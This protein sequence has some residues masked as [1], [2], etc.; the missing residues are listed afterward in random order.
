MSTVFEFLKAAS[1][2]L[3]GGIKESS[4]GGTPATQHANW[5]PTLYYLVEDIEA[6]SFGRPT[7]GLYSK[8]KP[9]EREGREKDS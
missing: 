2:G 9:N 5:G 8:W 3:G 7:F 6:V 1:A 4:P